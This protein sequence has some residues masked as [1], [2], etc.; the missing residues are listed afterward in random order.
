MTKWF[1]INT[2]WGNVYY[3]DVTNI[4]DI[5]KLYLYECID[6]T[7]YKYWWEYFHQ[8]YLSKTSDL[9]KIVSF[10]TWRR[11]DC[12]YL[13]N[14]INEAGLFFNHLFWMYSFGAFELDNWIIILG[15][16]NLSAQNILMN[17]ELSI[18]REEMEN[19]KKDKKIISF[20]IYE[21]IKDNNLY[22]S[23]STT[24]FDK[25]YPTDSDKT[26]R[27]RNIFLYYEE[28]QFTHYIEKINFNE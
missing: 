14:D 28:D 22:Q 11:G 24:D 16:Q 4:T 1:I 19:Y 5:F 10:L 3:K 18:S 20:D 15:T 7:I 25:T 21:Y 2:H 27:K 17:Y 9:Y 6:I 26:F 8:Y 12:I 13:L 23:M